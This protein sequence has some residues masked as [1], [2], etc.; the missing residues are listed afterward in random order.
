MQYPRNAKAGIANANYNAKR[1]MLESLGV[2]VTVQNGHYHI[3][4]VLGTSDGEIRKLER[5]GKDGTI[6]D[7]R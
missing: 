1:H 3:D 6:P 7:S 4:C 5:R 2:Q